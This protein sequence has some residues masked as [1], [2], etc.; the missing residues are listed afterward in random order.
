M[1]G[2]QWGGRA[3]GGGGGAKI[4]QNNSCS[5]SSIGRTWRDRKVRRTPTKRSIIVE[6]WTRDGGQGNE[7]GK[8]GIGKTE[9]GGEGSY[10][11]LFVKRINAHGE[12]G[13]EERWSEGIEAGD[14]GRRKPFRK[15]HAS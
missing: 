14:R 2:A 9:A 7:A 5:L 10:V 12:G 8:W 11:N 1:M 3:E 4:L 13:E 15:L 6:R